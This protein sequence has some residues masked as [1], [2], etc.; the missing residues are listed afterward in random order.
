M[1]LS[2]TGDVKRRGWDYGSMTQGKDLAALDAVEV[3]E[4]GGGI[5]VESGG[6]VGSI[7]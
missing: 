4:L 1:G 6:L 7:H 2:R 3:P 5:A